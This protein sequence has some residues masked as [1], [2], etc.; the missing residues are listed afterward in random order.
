MKKR[1]YFSKKLVIL[2]DDLDVLNKGLEEWKEERNIVI[3]IKTLISRFGVQTIGISRGLST[4]SIL[5]LKNV[6]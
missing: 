3:S 5:E 6:K 1:I 4:K 2:K